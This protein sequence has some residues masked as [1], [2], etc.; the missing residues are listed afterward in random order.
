[1][2]RVSERLDSARAALATLLEVLAASGAADMLRDAALLRFQYTFEA[3]WKAVRVYLKD[4]EGVDA[5][6]PK[7]A[8]R[9][10]RLAHLLH[11]MD[12]ALAMNMVDDRNLIVHTYNEPLAR[13]IH[14]RLPDYAAL[15]DRWLQA[16]ERTLRSLTST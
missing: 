2:D 9:Q 11:D 8:V 15:M 16:I 10:S 4:Q 5:G 7:S 13:D 12:A 14:A 1:M 6:T 3:V